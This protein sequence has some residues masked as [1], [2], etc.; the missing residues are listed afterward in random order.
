M[1]TQEKV[2][3]R[4]EQSFKLLLK[5]KEILIGYWIISIVLYIIWMLIFKYSINSLTFSTNFIFEQNN[6]L[7]FI[8]ILLYILLSIII[9]IA[10]FIWSVH[11][12]KEISNE[13]PIQLIDS[14][15]Y[16][17]DNI[18]RS[19]ITYYHVF[20]YVYL[21][22]LWLLIIWLMLILLQQT[23]IINSWT[24]GWILSLLSVMVLMYYIIYR[25]TKSMFA[26]YWAVDKDIY[27]KDNFVN[28]VNITK[29][30]WLRIFWNCLLLWLILWL[31]SSLINQIFS[32][33]TPTFDFESFRNN[34]NL[35]P[36]LIKAMFDSIF[37][38]S[39]GWIMSSVIGSII[40]IFS[41]T[42]YYLFYKRLEYEF[43]PTDKTDTSD[44]YEIKETVNL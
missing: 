39:I 38:I 31:S 32:Y 9:Q 40:Y 27:N 25:W 3:S 42:F 14:F 18:L 10:I 26:I 15:K 21:L 43:S 33:M 41:N 35:S 12:I 16:W 7:I 5:N 34:K 2:L 36:E 23:W 11:Y 6:I 29:N 37:T 20:I 22:P 4:I 1:Q 30:N 24:I 8:G 17:L 28:T 13:R 19:F 44:E